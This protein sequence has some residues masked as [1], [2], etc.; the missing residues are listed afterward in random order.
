MKIENNTEGYFVSREY[1]ILIKYDESKA[2]YETFKQMAS[3]MLAIDDLN[4][5]I[6]SSFGNDIDTQAFITD[7]SYG[8]FRMSLIDIVNKIPDEKIKA[9]VSNP[10]E[11]ISDI[12]IGAKKGLLGVLEE[13][14]AHEVEKLAPEIIKKEIERTRLKEFGYSID[15]TRVLEAMSELSQS[16]KNID[17]SISI[18]EKSFIV[19]PTYKFDV[20]KTHD[21]IKQVSTT[22]QKFIIKKPDL[23]GDS[24]W[25]IIFDKSIDVKILD[26]EW[27]ERLKKREFSISYGDRIDAELKIETYIDDRMQVVETRYYITKVYGIVEPC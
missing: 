17:V 24:K 14:D 2:T 25:T 23:V 19:R 20:T 1:E 3:L 8:S 18:D 5:A 15:K 4:N 10:K 7:I 26:T 27:I 16:S 6:A 9:Y 21:I 11:A 12:I 13:K 22:R